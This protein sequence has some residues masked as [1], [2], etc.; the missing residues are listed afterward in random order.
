[1][2][3]NRITNKT[4][5]MFQNEKLHL[6]KTADVLK[7]SNPKTPKYYATPNIYKLNN[8]GRTVKNSVQC[9][10]SEISRFVDQDLHHNKRNI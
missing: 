10:I 8:P 5:E 6:K 2:Q 3:H 9:H 1:M 4:I 7:L